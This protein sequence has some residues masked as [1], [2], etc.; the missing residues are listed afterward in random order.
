MH[1]VLTLSCPDQ[2]GIVR[3]QFCGL[4][5]VSNVSMLMEFSR[6]VEVPSN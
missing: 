2:P 5:L 4:P 1:Y 6:T 3:A